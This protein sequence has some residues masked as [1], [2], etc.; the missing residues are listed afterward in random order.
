MIKL[1]T[2][3]EY[4]GII[5]KAETAHLDRALR[6]FFELAAAIR[7]GLGKQGY[8]LDKYV[9]CVLEAA[10]AT[11]S[12]WLLRASQDSSPQVDAFCRLLTRRRAG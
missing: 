1:N 4:E 6:E 8:L 9:S 11:T 12:I 7:R 10:N 3:F 2:F 5:G